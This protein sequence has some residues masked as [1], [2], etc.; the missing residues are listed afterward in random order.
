MKSE[1]FMAL[2]FGV[3]A[4]LVV[5]AVARADNDPSARFRGAPTY[6]LAVENVKW[7]AATDQHSHVTFDLSW[8]CSWRAAWTEEDSVTGAPLK[9]ENWDA[10]WVFV[11]SLP[12]KDR[13]ENI[14]SNHWRHATL[15]PDGA[16]HVMAAGATNTVGLADDGSKGIGVFI[17]RDAIGHGN[18][19]FRGVKL[20]WLHGADKVD[21]RKAAL[22]AH[23]IAMVYVPECPFKMGTGCKSKVGRFADGPTRPLV[24]MVRADFATE[25]CGSFT[26][27]S[28]RGGATVPFLVDAAWSGPVAEGTN[29]RRIGPVA[30]RLWGTLVWDTH[31]R[32]PQLNTIGVPGALND[33]F[34]TG[35]RAF[36]CMKHEL[37]Q[38]Q[39]AAFLNSLPPDVAAKRAFVSGDGQS[40]APPKTER[41]EVNVGPGYRPHVIKEQDG[42][43]ITCSADKIPKIPIA[44]DTGK[45][46]GLNVEGDRD[47]AID[48]LVAEAMT[49]DNKPK[50]PPVYTAR[51][52]HRACNYLSWLDGFAY[53]VWAGLRPMTELEYEKA[54]RGPRQPVPCERAW[55]T[56]EG[57]KAFGA[58]DVGLP[59][60]RFTTG[61]HASPFDGMRR[62]GIFATAT[63]DRVASG[64]SYW[65]IMELG[66]NVAEYT[67]TPATS[68]GRAF[69]GTHGDGTVP[70][71]KPGGEVRRGGTGYNANTAGF[72]TAPAD[73][74]PE[75]RSLREGTD[76]VG[77]RG[78]D[79][80]PVSD[81]TRAVIPYHFRH[82]MSGWR[83]ARTVAAGNPPLKASPKPALTTPRPGTPRPEPSRTDTVRITNVRWEASNQEH[84]I[85]TLDLSW[86][87]SWRAAWTEAAERNVTGAP[88]KVESWDAAWVFVKYR[89]PGGGAFLP[90]TLST[91]AAHRAMPA[92]AA[93]AVGRSDDGKKGVGVFVY[94][95]AVG[96][97]PN[98]FKN[99]S[100]RWL[101]GTDKA[102]PGKATLVAHA[103]AMVYVP[104]GPFKSRSPF[105]RPLP[106]INSRG[107]MPNGYGAFYCMKRSISQGQYA[108]FLNS[109]ASDL[110]AA[111]YNAERY[112][113]L[114]HDAAKRYSP[115]LYGLNGYTIRVVN[116][117]Y[118]A[119]APDR[120][121]NFLSWPDIVSYAA[122]A[123]LRPITD[124]EYEKACRGPREPAK[125]QDV[126][127]G[128]AC[129][130][131]EAI[132]NTVAGQEA[133]YWGIREL[134][135]SGNVHEWPGTVQVASKAGSGAGFK[136]TH[137]EGTPEAPSDWPSTAFGEGFWNGA[138]IGTDGISGIGI[139]VAVAEIDRLWG[140]AWWAVDSDRTGRFG[141][142]AVRTAP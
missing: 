1:R 91:D 124:L 89:P 86:D 8:S 49:D 10:A 53:A 38:G 87:H 58:L 77:Q 101:H 120:A 80:N 117:V 28:W 27:G 6:D 141:A 23:P 15:S 61:N 13:K 83:G 52:P 133:S 25:E 100:L 84:S 56:T 110:A 137:G 63:S 41:I 54:C 92:G 103:I 51:V 60:E 123:G 16:H 67:V 72:D 138:W 7:E 29:A 69:R 32:C 82:Q 21:P 11:K 65:G 34:P 95:N 20:R 127:D 33:G 71:G 76:G 79:H 118:A 107:A 97:G 116:G 93:C 134:S 129:A 142:R 111:S 43:T 70:A 3:A 125:G 48:A 19:S 46:K 37:T 39:Y 12:E 35:Y 102:E 22:A 45:S 78:Y 40:D 62:V 104:E 99:V 109:V 112:K 140:S 59:T 74:P 108:E 17:Y 68:A 121:C 128:T 96:S 9:V 42:H 31:N 88:L 24:G 119:D 122:W 36:Y 26:D 64:G 94:K 66:G 30:G 18:N 115:K 131:A 130:P 75:Q 136:G 135:L 114:P 14:E 55:G 2:L 132:A 126:W 105:G 47:P 5:A 81:R 85:V 139:W 4:L 50:R 57:T 73:W 98:T 44:P 90:A 106:L 113:A